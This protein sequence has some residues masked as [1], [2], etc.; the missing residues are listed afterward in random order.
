MLGA[1][2][3]TVESFRYGKV[4]VIVIHSVCIGHHPPG[5]QSGRML[6][7]SLTRVKPSLTNVPVLTSGPFAKQPGCLTPNTCTPAGARSPVGLPDRDAGQ[8]RPFAVCHQANV[9]GANQTLARSRSQSVARTA[10]RS[11][12]SGQDDLSVLAGGAGLRP[13]PFDGTSRAGHH[14]RHSQQPRATP[15]GR[16]GHPV[17]MVEYPLVRLAS[18]TDSPKTCRRST[19]CLG[20][21][22]SD[23]GCYD[24]RE[25]TGG[26]GRETQ[27]SVR[28]CECPSDGKLRV[29][30]ARGFARQCSSKTLAAQGRRHWHPA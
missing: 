16:R 15:T 23:T 9:F 27:V 18:R 29:P 12:T 20:T 6:R 11:G 24:I 2:D 22:S 4:L 5:L 25:D 13:K 1:L 14:R 28:R 3:V 17:E 19:A 30:L 10:H 21:S 8:D 26:P 7:R